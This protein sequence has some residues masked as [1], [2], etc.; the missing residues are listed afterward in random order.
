MYDYMNALYLRFRRVTSR[1][2]EVKEM[3]EN[4]KES[5]DREHQKI[6]LQLSDAEIAYC[7]EAA[8]E[9]FVDGYCLASGIGEELK[10]RRYSFEDENEEAA[11]CMFLNEREI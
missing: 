10:N 1:S 11:K 3:Y 2:G 7:E 6:L 8:L 5:L 4:I 9:S